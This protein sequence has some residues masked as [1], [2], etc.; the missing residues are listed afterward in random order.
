MKMN[1]QIMKLYDQ[2][3]RLDKVPF[4]ISPNGIYKDRP[5][6]IDNQWSMPDDYILPILLYA[7]C[8]VIWQHKG[9]IAG[10]SITGL[11]AQHTTCIDFSKDDADDM[12]ML[13]LIETLSK[14]DKSKN[15]GEE[16]DD[17]DFMGMNEHKCM[18]KGEC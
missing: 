5:W 6:I 3:D 14:I 2:L 15:E 10:R 11:S 4:D 17:L 12:L 7:A 1:D 18:K 8:N 9:A 16:F 13:F